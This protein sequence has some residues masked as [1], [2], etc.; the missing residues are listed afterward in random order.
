MF[1][2]V[3]RD[4]FLFYLVSKV[5]KTECSN[6]NISE[7]KNTDNESVKSCSVSPGSCLGIVPFIVSQD[8]CNDICTNQQDCNFISY[9]NGNY[10]YV[11]T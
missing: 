3:S 6:K 11:N 4:L 2:P 9:K 5:L 8:N 1:F 7:M 10:N